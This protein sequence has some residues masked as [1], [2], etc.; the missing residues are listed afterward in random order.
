MFC[1]SFDFSDET[2]P[3]AINVTQEIIEPNQESIGT[4]NKMKTCGSVFF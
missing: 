1:L 2:R 4:S 3:T